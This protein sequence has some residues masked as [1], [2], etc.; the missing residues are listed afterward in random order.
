VT[1]YVVANKNNTL[2]RRI[3]F[4]SFKIFICSIIWIIGLRDQE[5]YCVLILIFAFYKMY[6]IALFY[7]AIYIFTNI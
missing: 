6:E 4:A 5:I 2:A 3:F 1:I 7:I